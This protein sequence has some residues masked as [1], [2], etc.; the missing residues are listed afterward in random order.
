MQQHRFVRDP[1]FRRWILCDGSLLVMEDYGN[2]K[3][4]TGCLDTALRSLDTALR[5]A[6][7][8]ALILQKPFY[9]RSLVQNEVDDQISCCCS[10]L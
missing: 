5:I 8:A 1:L 10:D 6:K 9:I 3:R 2:N 7:T 4:V